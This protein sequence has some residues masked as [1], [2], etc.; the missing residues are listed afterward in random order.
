MRARDEC[1][2][3]IVTRT[4][5]FNVLPEKKNTLC[6]EN[7]THR[8]VYIIIRNA[9]TIAFKHNVPSCHSYPSIAKTLVCLSVL[10]TQVSIKNSLRRFYFILL[11]YILFLLIFQFSENVCGKE[12]DDH[13]VRGLGTDVAVVSSMVFVAQFILSLC[14]GT[15]VSLSGTT[16]AVVYTASFLAF[17]AS[18][19]ATQIV[20]LGL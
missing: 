11:N 1:V 19:V 4:I 16:S 2:F 14:M 7:K 6:N 12:P 13:Q 3:R 9:Y 8:I 18:A 10:L 17:C 5:I 20:Y 15:I